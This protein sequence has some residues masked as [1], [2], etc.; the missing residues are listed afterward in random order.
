MRTVI[1]SKTFLLVFDEKLCILYGCAKFG[2]KNWCVCIFQKHFYPSTPCS[3]KTMCVEKRNW[4][5]F[6]L[7]Q[8]FLLSKVTKH[9]TVLACWTQ[10]SNCPVNQQHFPIII[11]WFDYLKVLTIP[12]L[13]FYVIEYSTQLHFYNYSFNCCSLCKH[14]F[15]EQ[16]EPCICDDTWMLAMIILTL[17]RTDNTVLTARKCSKE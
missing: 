7:V 6:G 11:A 2:T 14:I 17:Y 9:V 10:G 13:M 1:F 8:V 5:L 4:F 16:I 3:V 15:A 12:P